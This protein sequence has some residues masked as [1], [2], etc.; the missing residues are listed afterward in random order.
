MKSRLDTDEVKV[1]QSHFTRCKAQLGSSPNA[2]AEK[3]TLS[4]Y[5]RIWNAIA[6]PLAKCSEGMGG[7]VRKGGEG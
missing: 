3:M 7:G 2:A 1:A 5:C 4:L 6:V